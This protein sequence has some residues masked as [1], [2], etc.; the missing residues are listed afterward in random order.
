M[1]QLR[2]LAGTPV[3][4]CRG[5]AALAAAGSLLAVWGMALG[6]SSAALADF[7]ASGTHP[8]LIVLCNFS[9]QRLDPA[10][11][12]YYDQMYGDAGAGSRQYNFEDWWHD[13]SFGQL[14]V[15]G[16]TVADGPHADANGWYTASERRDT[17]S[18]KRDRFS[19]IVDCE[20]A[21]LPDVNYNNYYGVIAIFPEVGART[22]GPLSATGTS[23][24][25]NATNS[26]PTPGVTTTNYFPTPPFMMDVSDGLPGNGETVDVTAAHDNG[27]G[28]ET[29]TI[30]RGVNG[31]T[32]Q[33]HPARSGA[34]VPGDLGEAGNIG[35][36]SVTLADGHA[37]QLAQVILPHEGN[38]TGAQHETGHG[39]G[40]IHS[41][42]LSFSTA[43][44]RD[45]TDVM[46]A[47]TGTYEDTTLGTFFGWSVL[48][49]LPGDKGPG[50]DAID[51][52]LQGWIPSSRHYLFNNGTPHRQAVITLHALSDPSALSDSSHPLEA[53]IPASV[54]IQNSAPT[55]A[56]GNPLPP[57]NPP[58]C[59]GMDFGCTTSQYYT[60]EYRQQAGWDSGF[61]ASAVVVHLFGQDS[62]SYWVDQLPHGHG[63]LLY[64]GDE[65][66]DPAN[67]TYVA[68]NSIAGANAQVSLGS[69]KIT[70]QLSYS[71]DIA[72]DYHDSVTM[73]G[74]LTVSGAPVPYENV[75]FTLGGQHCS[76][77]TD[78]T[79]HASCTL[80]PRRRPGNYTVHARF[81]GDP[82]Y[83]PATSSAAFSITKEETA[84]IYTG[85]TVILRGASGVTLQGGLLEDGNPGAPIAGRKLT[86]KLG[87]QHCTGITNSA[88]TATCRLTFNGVLGPQPLAASF[89]GDAY[90]QPS[91]APGQT[92]IVFAFPARGAFGLGDATVAAAGLTTSITWWADDWSTLNSL[93]DGTAPS[94]FKGFVREVSLPTST[95]PAACGSDW[96]T[97][98]GNSASPP[99]GLP[100]YM[101]VL[102]ASQV[103]KS[104]T[105]IFGTTV[106]I[107]VV[108]VGKGY[109]P[110]PGH[111]GV[112]TIIATY[113]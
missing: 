81:G 98:P 3:G 42:S 16:T 36:S 84:T 11:A 56:N 88:G 77:T 44:Y 61:P 40:Y 12:S 94:A 66:V 27:D 15:A 73:A 85:P 90:Y 92:A 54:T 103:T 47:Y 52:D 82:A 75:R 30:V 7:G 13:V 60:L 86:L 91:T 21:A 19:K 101:G 110:N 20:N 50:L 4:R 111:H 71:G 72:G 10:P 28:T 107:V 59:S 45:S 69:S 32:A 109:A 93:S 37:Y 106:H 99:R 58:T 43:D 62:R 68:I 8:W 31:T 70:P 105:Q 87:R 22:T 33:P 51:L 102:V 96:I 89:G 57:T 34:G 55:D 23:V 53:K 63:G 39:F 76:G 14:S 83:A 100:S 113:C 80:T 35:Q 78:P 18:Y 46:S 25:I 49:S 6:T 64:A 79:G 112:G 2:R 95:P 1:Y 67:S 38:L 104:G 48:G 24:T 5:R 41:R 97:A 74:D 65:Y 108:K 9:N 26:S 17:W 29:F